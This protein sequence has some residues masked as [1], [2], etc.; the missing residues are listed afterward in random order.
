VAVYF[1][2]S[3]QDGVGSRIRPLEVDKYGRIRHWPKNFFGDE[4]T[5]V[6]GMRSAGLQRQ[7]ADE[8]EM[9]T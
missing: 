8:K 1:C 6:A 4:M 2:E 7:I 9:K 3:S 5:D